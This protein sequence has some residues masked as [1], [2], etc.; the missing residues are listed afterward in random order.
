MMILQAKSISKFLEPCTHYVYINELEPELY[1][2]YELLIPY[3]QRHTLKLR[4]YETNMLKRFDGWNVQQYYKFLCFEEVQDDYLILDSKNFFT[5]PCSIEEWKDTVGCGLFW[6]Y[7]EFAKLEWSKTYDYY[8]HKFGV[9]PKKLVKCETP[10][11]IEKRELEKIGNIKKFTEWFVDGFSFGVP[12]EFM[13]YSFL[14]NDKVIEAKTD[15]KHYTFWERIK[16]FSLT[17]EYNIKL[18][19]YKVIGFHN[20]YLANVDENKIK[21][22]INFIG[23]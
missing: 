7:D 13:C 23:L 8:S 20:R 12:S 22:Y 6:Y 17:P 14:I 15:R 1:K 19:D 2:W 10:F 16:D 11:L 5:Q 9:Q 4:A 18:S 21:S 3:Y